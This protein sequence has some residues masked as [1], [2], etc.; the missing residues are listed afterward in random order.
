MEPN[1]LTAGCEVHIGHP[2]TAE[3]VD[4]EF[5]GVCCEEVGRE[6]AKSLEQV[7]GVGRGPKQEGSPEEGGKEAF[8]NAGETSPCALRIGAH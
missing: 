2:K 1:P 3:R 6:E 5:G 7:R 8:Q 4:S